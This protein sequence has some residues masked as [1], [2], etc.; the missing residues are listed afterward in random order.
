[1]QDGEAG[2]KGEESTNLRA[3]ER[4]T[5]LSPCIDS[6]DHVSGFNYQLVLNLDDK[7]IIQ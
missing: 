5:A 2:N 4:S 7:T 3:V 1:M 6:A